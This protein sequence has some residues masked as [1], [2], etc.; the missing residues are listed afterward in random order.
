MYLREIKKHKIQQ[1]SRLTEAF[2]VGVLGWNKRFSLSLMSHTK[3]PHREMLLSPSAVFLE[4]KLTKHKKSGP[5]E[6]S[7]TLYFYKMHGEILS[8]PFVPTGS[9]GH[10]VQRKFTIKN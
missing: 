6:V 9:V 5:G 3:F 7:Y 8:R 1:P 10:C 2:K 4:T